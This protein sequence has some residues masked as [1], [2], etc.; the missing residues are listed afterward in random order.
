MDKP[1]S[2]TFGDFDDTPGSAVT[3]SLIAVGRSTVPAFYPRER[4]RASG[5]A[6]SVAL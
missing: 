5:M 2:K 1:V 6:A 3:V 4:G